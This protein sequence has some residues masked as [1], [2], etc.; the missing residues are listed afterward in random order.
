MLWVIALVILALVALEGYYT[1]AIR[2][3][4]AFLALILACS[5]ATV[6]AP[7]AAPILKLFDITHPILVS[8]LAPIIAWIVVILLVRSAGETVNYKINYYYKYKVSESVHLEWQR[9][10]Q[11]V[12]LCVG[13]LNGLIYVLALSVVIYVVG[14]PVRQLSSPEGDSFV[15]RTFASLSDSLK[16][17]GMDKAIASFLPKSQVFYDGADV[18]GDLFHN[19]LAQSRLSTYPPFLS[20]ME[21]PEFKTLATD[22]DFQEKAWLG[23]APLGTLLQHEKLKPIVQNPD[24][25]HLILQTLGGDLKDLKQYLESGESPKF[26]DILILGHWDANVLR[27][28]RLAIKNKLALPALEKARIRRQ[29][30]VAWSNATLTAFVDNKLLIRSTD[31]NNNPRTIQGTW[32]EV[33]GSRYVFNLVEGGKPHETEAT[34]EARRLV[35]TSKDDLPAVFER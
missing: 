8:I 31:T 26:D 16:Q 34:V 10:N 29:L 2:A 13:V 14:Y 5:L 15:M 9:L 28:Y 22:Q 7:A 20:L 12:G 6:L 19:R 18:A 21:K 24:Y 30:D 3:S 11:R 35:F 17:T 25:Y 23:K 1:G 32:K 33:S 4:F 27:S